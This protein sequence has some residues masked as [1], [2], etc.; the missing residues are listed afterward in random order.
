MEPQKPKS[1]MTN[2]PTLTLNTNQIKIE[3]TSAIS[4]DNVTN[5]GSQE[6]EIQDR[7][8]PLSQDSAAKAKERREAHTLAEKRRR[9]A[10][11]KGYE[12]LQKVLPLQD[13]NKDSPPAKISKS[14]I[15]HVAVEYLEFLTKEDQMNEERIKKLQNE[16]NILSMVA[17]SYQNIDQFSDVDNAN[18]GSDGRRINP[19]QI[20]AEIFECFSKEIFDSFVQYV[21]TT[22]IESLIN[23]LFPWINVYLDET[24][25]PFSIQKIREKIAAKFYQ[26]TNKQNDPSLSS[27]Q[28]NQIS[29]LVPNI[30]TELNIT[31]STNLDGKVYI[32]PSLA[33]GQNLVAASPAM[34]SLFHSNSR[35]STQNNILHD[36]ITQ[37]RHRHSSSGYEYNLNHNPLSNQSQNMIDTQQHVRH[38]SVNNQN[39]MSDSESVM[40]MYQSNSNHTRT[41]GSYSLTSANHLDNN[42]NN[43]DGIYSQSTILPSSAENQ[44]Q[45]QQQP[46]SYVIYPNSTSVSNPG[47]QYN[48]NSQINITNN[49]TLNFAGNNNSLGKNNKLIIPKDEFLASEQTT[50]TQLTKPLTMSG[51]NKFTTGKLSRHNATNFDRFHNKQAVYSNLTRHENSL[52]L[53]PDS[54]D[55]STSNL[56]VQ[57]NLASSTQKNNNNNNNNS[58]INITNINNLNNVQNSSGY[59]KNDGGYHI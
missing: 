41:Q 25:K 44:Q 33:Q 58:S 38:M 51:I 50:T 4:P 42:A 32:E 9:D 29:N 20:K 8:E 10:I 43:L 19:D 40:E 28:T 34:P 5:P 12:D 3:S 18:I 23:S 55:Q 11:N 6:S 1:N 14:S 39:Y 36:N 17:K 16:E 22:N 48:N 30:K 45:Q 53:P 59:D 15:L 47:N 2:L 7:Q 13:E 49:T 46:N 31:S 21:D 56:F 35:S 27:G 57:Q 24:R 26:N 52:Y 54:S 37:P